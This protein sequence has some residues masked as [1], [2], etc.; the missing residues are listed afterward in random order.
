MYNKTMII[1]LTSIR[2]KLVNFTYM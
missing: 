2:A 1:D